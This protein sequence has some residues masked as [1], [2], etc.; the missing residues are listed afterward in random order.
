MYKHKTL[1]RKFITTNIIFNFKYTK[2]LTESYKLKECMKG[3]NIFL[4]SYCQLIRKNNSR[5]PELKVDNSQIIKK[6]NNTN[7]FYI[8]IYTFPYNNH[9]FIIFGNLLQEKYQIIIPF[10]GNIGQIDIKEYDK[11]IDYFNNIE[12]KALLLL[13][14]RTIHI[15]QVNIIDNPKYSLLNCGNI[16]LC[17]KHKKEINNMNIN[18]DKKQ[19]YIE[20]IQNYYKEEAIVLLKKYFELLNQNKIVEA[21]Y[22]LE[23]KNN[24][25]YPMHKKR[26]NTFYIKNKDIIGHLYIF[27]K[28]YSLMHKLTKKR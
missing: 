17:I 2:K 21:K 7:M 18:N 6:P 16:K 13:L 19:K 27:I 8:F 4:K 3:F 1:K 5:F 23:G 12:K 26:I 14:N 15:R 22:L 11:Y 20:L 24:K 9:P 28:L 10:G 25:K